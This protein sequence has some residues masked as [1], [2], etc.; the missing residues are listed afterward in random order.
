MPNSKELS[1]ANKPITIKD[2]KWSERAEQVTG[3]L[4]SNSAVEVVIVGRLQSGSYYDC[5]LVVSILTG[6]LVAG[7]TI[8]VPWEVPDY[9]LLCLLA[10]GFGLGGL[11][12]R[13][14]SVYLK[15][16]GAK[17]RQ[18][19][20]LNGAR[21]AFM[22]QHVSSTRDRSGLL[23]YLSE[24][25]G[26]MVILPDYGIQN[27]VSDSVWNNLKQTSSK[28]RQQTAWVSDSLETLL[29]LKPELDLALPRKSDD[30]NELPNAPQILEAE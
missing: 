3:E 14:P 17:R 26:E 24:R 10:M 25:E 5:Q 6:W 1:Q 28:T 16:A 20:V 22:T 13:I 7:A 27:K 23:V 4:E 2:P 29:T 15:L 18:R 30:T 11:V 21:A 9:W 12:G 19:Q 8:M